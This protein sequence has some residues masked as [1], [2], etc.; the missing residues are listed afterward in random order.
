[1]RKVKEVLRREYL[2]RVRKKSFWVTTFIIPILILLVTFLPFIFGSFSEKKDYKI[3]VID[4]DGYVSK[5]FGDNIKKINS[6]EKIIF[7]L[8]SDGNVDELKKG[9]LNKKIS[10]F[11]VVP[12]NFE[13]GHISFY[14]LNTNNV[15]LISAINNKFKGL[16]I[17]KR[18][19]KLNVKISR[20][21]LKKIVKGV[22]VDTFKITRSGKAKKSYFQIS[23]WIVFSFIFILYMILLMY[24]AISMRGVIEEKSSRIMEVLLSI[25]SPFELMMGK[26]LGIGFVGLTQILVYITFGVVM[27][28]F[29]LLKLSLIV[30]DI[31]D[32]IS[33][34]NFS[35]SIVIYYIIFFLLGYFMFTSMFLGIGS[36]CSTEEDAQN[37]QTPVVF[38]IIIPFISTIYLIQHPESTLSVVFSL[39]PFFTPMVMFM[40]VVTSNPPLWQVLFSI[41]FTFVFTVFIVKLSAKVFR[42]GVLMYG[43]RPSFKEIFRWIR[44]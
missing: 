16:A 20:D 25:Y 17:S 34:F 12:E 24:G 42:I 13:D 33:S 1:M 26:L 27:V 35:F 2:E 7:S 6:R 10:G 32:L 43:K 29:A 11:I 9:V 22:S 44:E 39:I 3:K 28:S 30:P 8:V 37:I 15:T 31:S 41:F 14:T 18:L 23:F 19:K 36:L 4:N 5:N 38:L 21:E 40:R